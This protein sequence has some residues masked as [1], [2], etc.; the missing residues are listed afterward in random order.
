MPMVTRGK[1]YNYAKMANPWKRTKKSPAKSLAPKT[2][3]AVATIAKQIVRRNEETKYVAGWADDGS[4]GYL[5]APYG[6]TPVDPATPAL[7]S[8]VSGIPPV[9]QGTGS[10]QRIGDKIKPISFSS[11]V[12]LR[13]NPDT[14]IK[15]IAP[16]VKVHIWY[17]FIRKL[18]GAMTIPA[19][20]V[21]AAT[22]ATLLDLGNGVAGAWGGD[23]AGSLMPH[24]KNVVMMKHRVVRL[25]RSQGQFNAATDLPAAPPAREQ[26]VVTLK[27]KVPSVL[28]FFGDS[29][30]LPENYFPV[31][32]IGYGVTTDDN[33]LQNIVEYKVLKQLWYK[34][35]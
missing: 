24:N 27:Y 26:T 29:D 1:K 10:A 25:Y 17:G 16:D 7:N 34:D 13:L 32:F 2:R 18:N 30:V 3:Q 23:L 21:Y 28:R 19:Q 12:L 15:S 8:V 9:P 14:A 20:P 33:A 6:L 22:Q 35:A 31:M 4:G 11:K 5:R